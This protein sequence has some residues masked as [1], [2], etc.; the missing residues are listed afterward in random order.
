MAEQTIGS[1]KMLTR[2]GSRTRLART[3]IITLA[4]VL[5]VVV[6]LIA[7]IAG[8]I[9][10]AQAKPIVNGHLR[11]VPFSQRAQL[12][13]AHFLRDP[14][15]WEDGYFDPTYHSWPKSRQQQVGDSKSVK[16]ASEQT[17][18]GGGNRASSS[19]DKGESS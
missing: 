1:D 7:T 12:R 18:S 3:Q 10:L 14:M 19:S 4:I 16:L 5:V 15:P 8:P 2:K 11:E 17:V 6:V 13:G 9:E